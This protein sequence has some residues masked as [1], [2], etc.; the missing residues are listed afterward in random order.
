MIRSFPKGTSCGKDGL[1]AQHLLDALSGVAVAI[2]DELIGSITCV[3]NLFLGGQCPASLGEFLASAPLTPLLKPGGGVRPIVVGSVWRRSVSKVAASVVGKSLGP[4]LEDAQ[5]GVGVPGGGEAVLH[6]VNR[7]VES[8]G[9]DNSL[10]LLLVDFMNA[11]NLVDR[12]DMINEVHRMCPTISC[13]VEFCYARPARLYYEDHVLYSCQGV[14]QGD[15]L[16]P[17]LF[18]LVL[19]PLIRKIMD[20][21]VLKLNACTP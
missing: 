3:V 8:Q 18:S 11:F 4:Y 10:T 12:G 21:C 15:P 7:L 20:N 2:A 14:Q 16:G 17:L 5:F 19:H 6:V 13:W 1:R 9:H